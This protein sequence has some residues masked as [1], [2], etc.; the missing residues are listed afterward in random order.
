MYLRFARRIKNGKEHRYWGIVESKRCA[1][2]KVVQRPVLYLGEINDS[3][4]AAWCR[5]IETLDED[6]QRYRQLA[7]FP[8]DRG[9]PEH[10]KG[11]GVQVRLEAMQLHRPR[12]WGACWLACELYEQ[13]QLDRFWAARLPDSREGTSWRHIL[14]TLVCY[15]LIDPGSEWRLHRLWF[16]QSAMGDLLGEDYSLVEKNALYRCLD[17]ILA[18]KQALFS[19]LRQ[20]WQDLFGA[21]FDVLLYDLTSTYFECDP[22]DNDQDKRRFGHSRDKRK[23]CV[24]VVIALVVTPDGFPL[25]YEVLAGNT[26]DS[27]TLRAFLRKIEEQYGKAERIWVMDRGIPTEEVLAEMRQSNPPIYYLV[28]TP[29]GRLT[30]LEKA[31]L[32]LPWQGVREGVDVKLLP[33]DEELYVLAKSDARILKERGIRRRKLRWLLARLKEISKMELQRDDLLMK[34]GATRAKAPAA[35]RLVDVEVAPEGATFSYALNRKKFRKA[36]RREGRYLLRTNL[37]GRDPA[38][39]WQFYIQLVEVEAA[40]KNLKDDLQLRPIYHQLID[41]IEAHIFVAFLAYCLQVTLR[42]RLRPLASGLTP[43]AVL[44]KFAAIQMLDVHFPT[45]DG[46]TLILSRYTELNAD[47]KLLMKQL[48]LDLPAQPRP[49]ITAGGQIVR[50]ASPAL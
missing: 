45:I 39:L 50:A 41:R 31:L 6:N 14:Q 5:V 19:H 9:V 22:P 7:L 44:D 25:G 3:Q 13:L 40:F 42:A 16:E 35:W 36:W 15:R 17:K 43:R 29:K 49:R 1:G 37:S 46:R 18:H 21:K 38:Q 20:R 2:G 10:A 12:Q 30:K 34:L 11:Y 33:K 47:Q 48:K 24:Q 27:T 28:G 26:R 32:K 8:A 4:H 23:D